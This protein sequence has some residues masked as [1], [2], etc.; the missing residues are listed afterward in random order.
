MSEMIRSGC[1]PSSLSS[2]CWNTKAAGEVT[3]DEIDVIQAVHRQNVGGQHAAFLTHQLAG[4]RDQPPGA[5]P[6][7][8]IS[9]PGRISLSFSFSSISL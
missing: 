3:L 7:S 1:R 6:R 5:E 9:M 4:H 2:S 8:M